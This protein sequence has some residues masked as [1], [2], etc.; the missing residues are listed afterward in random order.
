MKTNPQRV[1]MVGR[2]FSRLTVIASGGRGKNK[3][4]HW[5]CECACGTIVRVSGGHLRSGWSKSC[6]CLRLDN[7]NQSRMWKG[8]GELSAKYWSAV[9]TSAKRREEKVEISIEYA[10][11]LFQKQGGKC[12][13]S[14]MNLVFNSGRNANYSSDQTASLDRINSNLSYVE[15]NVQWVHK[16]VNKMKQSFTDEYYIAMCTEVAKYNEHR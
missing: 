11:D 9:K 13:L 7:G 15:G 16:H 2:K 6:G 12:A 10:W 8:A 4:L 14:G 1:A 3:E 5:R